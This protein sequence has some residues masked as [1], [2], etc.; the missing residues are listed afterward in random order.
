MYPNKGR[1]TKGRGGVTGLGGVSPPQE[2]E[3]EGTGRMERGIN[4]GE[5]LG[6]DE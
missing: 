6:N 1:K 2:E 4:R 5:V 3:G